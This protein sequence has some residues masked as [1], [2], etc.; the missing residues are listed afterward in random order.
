MDAVKQ[1]QPIILGT[2]QAI[3]RAGAKLEGA[4][5]KKKAMC[6][7]YSPNSPFEI[8]YISALGPKINDNDA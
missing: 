3:I 5:Y 2:L 1:H 8:D 7:K 4:N 6:E